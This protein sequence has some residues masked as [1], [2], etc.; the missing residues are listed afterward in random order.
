MAGHSPLVGYTF[1]MTTGDRVRGM[2]PQY[3]L[4][5]GVFLALLSLVGVAIVPVDE[6]LVTV[7]MEPQN[8][9][10]IRDGVFSVRVM[11]DAGTPVNVFKGEV[12]FDH[13]KLQIESIDYNTSIAELWAERPWYA[14][15]EGTMNFIGGTT[16]TGGFLGTGE[17]ITIH[18]KS[19]ALGEAVLSLRDTQVLAHDGLGS[20]VPLTEPLDALFTVSD[21]TVESKAVTLKESVPASVSVVETLPDTDLNDDGEQTI[22]DVSIFIAGFLTGDARFDFNGDT[23]VDTSDLSIIMGA[24]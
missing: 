3:A 22:A 13:T 23:S 19:V 4:F 2:I 16:R 20:D 17:L 11:I 5:A 8:G 10:V 24:K 18:F 12:Q 6:P 15:G 1:Y 9:V 7:R 14:N 21:T